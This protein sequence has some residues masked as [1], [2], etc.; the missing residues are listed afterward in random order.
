M[1]QVSEDLL[2]ILTGKSSAPSAPKAASAPAKS[3]K[4]Y[5]PYDAAVR[6]VLA[7]ESDPTAQEWVAGVIAN[8]AK[9]SGKNFYEVVTEE[10]QFEPWARGT[11]QAVDPN[12]KEYKAA[13]ERLKDILEG[14]RDPSGGAMNFYAPEAQA[15][16]SKKDGRPAKAE[17][18]DGTGVRVGNT[19]FFRPGSTQGGSELTSILGVQPD[20]GAAEAD[21]AKAF[22]DPA[23]YGDKAEMISRGVT[24][25]RE[26]KD[27][28][29]VQG[30]LSKP[31]EE[32]YASLAKGGGYKPNDPEGSAYNMLF[33]QEGV[34][35]KD[36]PPGAYYVTRDGEFK[37]AAGGDQQ[38]GSPIKGFG[39]GAADVALS[40]ANAMPGS[41]D[42]TIKNRL[43]TDQMVYD[44]DHKGELNAGL[45]RFLGQSV[46]A[47]P[48]MAGAEAVALP[49]I[50]GSALGKF[51]L[52][53]GGAEMAPGAMKA[54]T[55][56]GSK[57]TQGAAEGAGGAALVSSASDEPLSDQLA[58]GAIV[59]GALRPVVP[60][61]G[62]LGEKVGSSV[63]DL[64]EPW[65]YSG[66]EKG[67]ERILGKVG[68]DNVNLDLREL[69]PG[70]K[71]TMAEASGNAGLA[72]LER[73]ART[74][75]Q[76][77]ERFNERLRDNAA[78]RKDFF[79]SIAK[80]GEAIEEAKAA[81][82][83][84]TANV[85]E[86]AFKGAGAADSAPVLAKVDEILSGPS[87][88]RDVVTK[89]LA[90]IRS[91][92]EGQT[93]VQQLY[94]I[95]KAIGD[96]LDPLGPSETK[97]AVLAKR[98]L[99]DVK[100]A[101]DQAIEKAAPGFKGYLKTYAEMS[102]PID[103]M[104]YLQSLNL[105]DTKGFITLSK[106]QTAI[107]RIEKAQKAGGTNK[108]KS[109]SKA[110]MDGLKALRDDLKRSGNIDLGKARGSD[111]VQNAAMGR[112]AADEGMP[113]I[114]NILGAKV[115]GA[116]LALGL[117][118][119]AL[120]GKSAK[121]VDQ[122]ASRLLYPETPVKNVSV[123]KRPRAIP[124]GEV[125]LPVIGGQFSSSVGANK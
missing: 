70:S 125:A 80:D 56:L 59:G 58:T 64:V 29:K 37:R 13:A 34:S 49:A 114:G 6:T 95:R 60:A 40:V 25:F 67:V 35:E 99:M 85:R 88:Q 19:L 104:Q 106:V 3:A 9:K 115:P 28:G 107:D 75:P 78:A 105:A 53:K 102:K 11:A 77:V 1:D 43:R 42:S 21:F 55:K 8:R 50:G 27:G 46:A 113:V 89:A 72:T 71:P 48:L 98:E 44:A 14:K 101:L 16:L 83:A 20:T 69:V 79:G 96:M 5:D 121:A 92:L 124:V 116:A 61:V 18:D 26:L 108:Q 118:K 54:I 110:T 30:V 122:L 76:L 41:D 62:K 24:P 38:D 4:T 100:M 82:E 63:R 51:I 103:E 84:A 73:N 32:L 86:Q 90:S 94:G 52:G 117:G 87:G 57:L 109:I 12:S 81:R 31:Q 23:K 93:D 68:G 97:G 120:E 111:T 112:F 66:R 39:Q 17:F 119:K 45:G 7:E 91:K 2:S 10:N 36:I 15:E 65:T 47:I 22:G 123:K 74:N 33:M